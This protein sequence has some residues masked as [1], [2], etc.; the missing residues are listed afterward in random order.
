MI[1]ERCFVQIAAIFPAGDFDHPGYQTSAA[2]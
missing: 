1:R 2:F